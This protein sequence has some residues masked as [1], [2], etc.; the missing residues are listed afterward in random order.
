MMEDTPGDIDARLGLRVRGLRTAGGFSLD[1]VARLSGV[2]RSMISLIERG[3]SSPT[4]RVLDRLASALGVSLAALFDG[5][6]SSLDEPVARRGNQVTWRDPETGYLRRNLS[7]AGHSSAVERVEVV[8]PP[9]ARVAYDGRPEA[10]ALDQQVWVLSGEVEIEIAG[11]TYR[12]SAGDCLTMRPRRPTAFRNPG[13]GEAS[14][15]VAVV[16]PKQ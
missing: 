5:C 7:P 1:D 14:Y 8:I 6:A 3:E 2:S 16:S 11:E 10:S 12:L 13:A 9:G 15:L 4:A